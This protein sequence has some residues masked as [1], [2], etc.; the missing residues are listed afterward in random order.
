MV[1]IQLIIG[2]NDEASQQDECWLRSAQVQEEMS[3]F[4]VPHSAIW[5]RKKLLLNSASQVSPGLAKEGGQNFYYILCD[6]HSRR[7]MFLVKP[8]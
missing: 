8:L 2:T 1:C 4:T 7:R 6:Q 5:G 3:V